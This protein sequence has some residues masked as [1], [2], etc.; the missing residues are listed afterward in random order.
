MPLVT[1]TNEQVGNFRPHSEAYTV[2]YARSLQ[3][4]DENMAMD[5]RFFQELWTLPRA[6]KPLEHGNE[7]WVGDLMVGGALKLIYEQ[8]HTQSATSLAFDSGVIFRP[9]ETPE[10][11]LSF[12]LLNV[13]TRP[14]FHTK[15]EGLPAEANIGAAY[16]F[17]WSGHRFLPAVELSVPYYGRPSGKL[18]FEYS[19]MITES[20]AMS[21]RLGYKSLTLPELDYL[22]GLTGGIGFALRQISLDLAFQPM[23]VLGESYRGTLSYRF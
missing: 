19:T 1:N 7:M 13:G 9:A 4:G 3:V 12:A 15:T 6:T 22:T 14:R 17:L 20:S 16:N 18:G 21:F 5:R 11:S 2:A 23:S 8:I 10:F